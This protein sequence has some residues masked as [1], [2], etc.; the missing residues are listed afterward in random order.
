MHLRLGSEEEQDKM[1]NAENKVSTISQFIKDT[2]KKR[3]EAF[4]SFRSERW[5]RK[6]R[7]RQENIASKLVKGAKNRVLAPVKSLFDSILNIIGNPI[8][9]RLPCGQSTIQNCLATSSKQSLLLLTAIDVFN[10]VVD[11]FAGIV[12]FGYGLVDGFRDWVEGTFGEDVA[13]KLDESTCHP[14]I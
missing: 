6:K 2:N 12:D 4:K 10:K 1:Q 14:W 13:E 11:I 9:G 3:K 8:F 7:K 5:T